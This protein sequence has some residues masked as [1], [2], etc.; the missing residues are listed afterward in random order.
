MDNLL[1]MLI[2]FLFFCGYCLLTW[3]KPG[4]GLTL[5]PFAVTA[6]VLLGLTPHRLPILIMGIV[7]FPVTICLVYWMPHSSPLET[8]WYKSAAKAVML[9]FQY[10]LILAF[11][12][13]VFNV[14]GGVL[15]VLLVIGI[16]RYFLVC[17]YSLVLDMV[18][19]IGMS[20]RQSL[21][22]PM[23]LTTAASGRKRKQAKIFNDT[24][25]WLTQGYSLTEALR[26]GYRKFPPDL[27]A[28]IA[29]GEKMNQL[30]RTIETIIADIAEKMDDYKK[31]RPVHIWYPAVV[32]LIMFTILLGLMYFII[33]TFAEVLSDMSDGMASLPWL[34]RQLLDFS[35]W[36]K[37]RY[38]LNI[39]LIF[40]LLAGVIFYLIYVRFRRRNPE[41]PR[42]L[43]IIGDHIK[44]HLPVSHWFAANYS[45]LQ[46]TEM[47]KIG[48]RAGY[49]VNI[50]VRNA[51]G[52]DMNQCYR[53]RIG[54]WLVRI[55][56]G[57]NLAASAAQC[58][59]GRTLAWAL[60]GSIN[61]GNTLTVLETLEEM[62]RS[63]YHYRL[64]LLNAVTCPLMV[65]RKSVV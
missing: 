37:G 1:P 6:C 3:K 46:L 57:D 61:K 28:A 39:L 8:P 11:M 40:M 14:F 27:L 43:S 52:L 32:L 63:R 4:W 29:A 65:D 15:F 53:K 9:F 12:A 7:L 21:P 38:G 48:L 45:Q 31:V 10:L 44:W 35:F 50:A 56:N 58:S 49:P 47:L 17:K 41:S 18:T 23:A 54:K 42:L 2:A 64:N 26:R 36:L 20:M 25:Y 30:P 33:P 62:Y 55:E 34:T 5:L 59:I 60:D 22:L 13:Y 51:L 24:A 19:T 16:V